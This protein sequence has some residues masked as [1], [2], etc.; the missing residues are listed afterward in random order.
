MSSLRFKVVDEAFNRK[1]DPVEIPT[2]RPEIYYGKQVFNR[3]KMFEYLP[4][5]TFEALIYA[6]DNKE[7]LPRDVADSVAANAKRPHNLNKK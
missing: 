7:P 4:A 6:I 5:D 1:A 2:E 3:Q